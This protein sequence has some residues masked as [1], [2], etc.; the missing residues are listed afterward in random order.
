VPPDKAGLAAGLINTSQWLGAA[1]GLAT[2]TAIATSRTNH[3]L[4]QQA[5]LPFALT[6]GLR[7]AL[8]CC[9]I[10]LAAAALIGLRA[11]NTRGE[12]QP[13]VDP[14]LGPASIGTQPA[15]P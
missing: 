11:T 12:P 13:I 15:Q 6:Q 9:S 2:F 5:S 10:F 3:L 1:L 7:L 8:L 4:A 14:V